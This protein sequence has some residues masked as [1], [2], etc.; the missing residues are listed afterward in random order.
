MTTSPRPALDLAPNAADNVQPNEAWA[1]PNAAW[2]GLPGD[3]A[4]FI[5]QILAIEQ[6]DA[7]QD[8]YQLWDMLIQAFPNLLDGYSGVAR[9]LHKLGR[10]DEAKAVRCAM[11]QRFPD[12]PFLPWS[13][14]C[15]ATEWHD[16][17]EA[18]R[19]WSKA[20]ALF[21]ER[22]EP[23]LISG[24]FMRQLGRHDEADPLLRE[25]V[26]RFPAEPA[27][28]IEFALVARDQGRL[29]E[30]LARLTLVTERFPEVF[31]GWLEAGRL[32]RDRSQSEQAEAFFQRGMRH[33]PEQ[34]WLM[35]EY[36]QTPGQA[37][38]PNWPETLPRMARLRER[39]P[40]F[41]PGFIHGVYFLIAA[42]RLD[43][44][45]ALAKAGTE[46]FPGSLQL[47]I[48]Y[49][50][51][52]VHGIDWPEA[53]RRFALARERFPDKPEV[54]ADLARTLVKAGRAGEAEALTHDLMARFPRAP[55]AFAVH[56]EV[57][58]LR[59]D[60]LESHRR[61][62][63]AAQRFPEAKHF[64]KSVFE[65]SLRV[66]EME[67]RQPEPVSADRPDR[68][69]IEMNSAELAMQFTSLGASRGGC[70]FGLFQRQCGAEPLDLLRWS[71]MSY[72]KLVWMLECRFD[73]VGSEANT[74]LLVA[75]Q[76][77]GR[78]EYCT[79][80]RR[81][82]MEMHSF[83]YVD[84]IAFDQMYVASC[85]RLRFLAGK[86]IGDL[87][88]GEKIF[89]YSASGRTL[90]TD[91]VDA[92]H[93]AMRSYGDNTLL[94][95]RH[96]DTD[97]PNGTVVAMKPG[98]MI[99]YLDRFRLARDGSWTLSPAM[100]SWQAVCRAAYGLWIAGRA[101]ADL[102]RAPE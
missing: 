47:A 78:Q 44:A 100:A 62:T 48:Q 52:A 21:P 4:G 32:V 80:D 43:A 57:A 19:W 38:L 76:A 15:L 41:E 17:P 26:Q 18:I 40:D 35:F 94:F 93:A 23:W 56:A 7:W 14:A 46:Q 31:E 91:Q 88:A 1:Q 98:L 11:L 86:L 49:A 51:A 60:W 72:E 12:D 101:A 68:T 90:T 64:A 97:Y 65:A 30:A 61:W 67:T 20:R 89:V 8:A 34:P 79:R 84:E 58:G 13:L 74:E 87:E 95:V 6:S 53:I 39:F 29:D 92:L 81:G 69:G 82:M 10:V 42:R 25:A 85:R 63:E 99:G 5:E 37:A 96:E 83:R 45:E 75:P 36:A 22:L 16:L 2:A 54:E 73:G 50:R 77:D 70:E 9:T 55:V 3:P 24:R 66:A 33:C 27:S 102:S 59:Q 71:D 28:A